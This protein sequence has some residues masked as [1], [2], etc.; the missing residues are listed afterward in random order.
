[1]NKMYKPF[2]HVLSSKQT[3]LRF[4]GIYAH[5]NILLQT[6]I[7]LG[8]FLTKLV[9]NLVCFDILVWFSPKLE[10]QP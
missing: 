8:W 3:P 7:F 4:S 10:S 2:T 5:G 9:K 1:M 6:L